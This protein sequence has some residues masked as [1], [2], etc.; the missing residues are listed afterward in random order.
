M[1]ENRVSVIRIGMYVQMCCGAKVSSTA[2]VVGQNSVVQIAELA[3]GLLLLRTGVA[4]LDNSL[5]AAD[6]SITPATAV[7]PLAA[8][9]D[10]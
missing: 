9:V 1:T 10:P 5:H 7:D 6:L 3:L 8:A 4:A 2:A